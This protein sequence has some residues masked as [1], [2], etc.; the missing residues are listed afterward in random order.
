MAFKRKKMRRARSRRLFART[1]GPVKRNVLGRPMRG[2][3]RL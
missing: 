2:G 3:I 1:A